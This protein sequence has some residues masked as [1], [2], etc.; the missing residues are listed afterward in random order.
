MQALED[1][2]VA[3]DGFESRFP[4]SRRYIRNLYSSFF[5]K[6]SMTITKIL[7]VTSSNKKSCEDAIFSGISKASETISDI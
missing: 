6:E 1:I 2:G 7:E 3:F 5:T 4:Q